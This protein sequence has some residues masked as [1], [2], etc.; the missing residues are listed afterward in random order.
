M[1][2]SHALMD[3]KDRFKTNNSWLATMVGKTGSGKSWSAI[4]IAE[5]LDP[6]FTIDNI[7]FTSDEFL[8][9]LESP[10][11]KRGSFIIFDEAG[12]S[13]GA[14]DFYTDVN[15]ALSAVLQSMRALNFGTIFTVPNMSFVDK[16]ARKLVHSVIETL[17]INRE[18]GYVEAK[19]KNVWANPI[20]DMKDP[21][22]IYP[23]HLTGGLIRQE[24]R[25]RIYKASTKLI[26]EYEKKKMEFLHK[27]IQKSAETS[28]KESS[29]RIGDNEIQ[30]K[31]QAD[32]EKGG[33]RPTLRDIQGIYGVGKDRA[34]FNLFAVW[35]KRSRD[36]QW[37]AKKDNNNGVIDKREDDI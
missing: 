21:Y 25:T 6:E 1:S 16:H 31:L 4:K 9:L 29:K 26:E 35:G 36:G 11:L 28:R 5:S 22:Y 18:E 8:A 30:A 13:F 37:G 23:T 10:R 20:R 19:W 15:K 2:A 12:I 7:V 24:S 27:T 33:E 3:V 34:A 14:R 32:K 17:C